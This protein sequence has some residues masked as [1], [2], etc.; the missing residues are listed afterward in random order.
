MTTPYSA[1]LAHTTGYQRPQTPGT[2]VD[3]QETH[4][5]DIHGT[6][7]SPGPRFTPGT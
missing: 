4:M 3:D 6:V 7:H 2:P 1:Q 5:A